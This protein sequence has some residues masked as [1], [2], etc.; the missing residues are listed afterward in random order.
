M[1]ASL[2]DKMAANNQ[3]PCLLACHSP[4]QVQRLGGTT[5]PA[6]LVTLL[7]AMAIILWQHYGGPVAGGGGAGAG[8]AAKGRKLRS[9]EYVD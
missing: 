2:P 7:V 9:T 6:L 5:L 3:K 4:P 8:G 1:T